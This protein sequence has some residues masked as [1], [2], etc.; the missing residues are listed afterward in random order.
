MGLGLGYTAKDHLRHLSVRRLR[1]S[2]YVCMLLKNV[3]HL[4][5]LTPQE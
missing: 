2:G 1:A 5:A 4:F 3:S